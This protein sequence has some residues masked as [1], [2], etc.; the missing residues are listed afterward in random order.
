MTTRTVEYFRLWDNRTW[1]TDFIDLPADTPND[2]LEDAVREAAAKIEW[3]SEV[4]VVVGLYNEGVE[5]D[6]AD[7][8][9]EQWEA[10][11]EAMGYLPDDDTI[12]NAIEEHES[13]DTATFQTALRKKETVFQAQGGRGV[14]LADQI[15]SLR[16]ALVLRTTGQQE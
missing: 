12:T 6:G 7:L 14:E 15:D 10:I 4:P 16:I 9:D 1:D 13:E 2:K 3:D 8:T 5:E 11:A